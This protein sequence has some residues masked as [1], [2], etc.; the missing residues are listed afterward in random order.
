MCVA[1]AHEG[2][3]NEAIEHYR[4]ALA[5]TPN[6]PEAFINWGNVLADQGRLTEAIEHY[7]RALHI[8]LI[9]PRPTATGAVYSR[10]RATWPRRSNTT[11]KR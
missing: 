11:N 2:T 1:L 3:P 6:Y 4:Q 8:K 5:R 10:N 9:L 7:Q